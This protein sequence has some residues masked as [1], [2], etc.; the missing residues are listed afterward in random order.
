MSTATFEANPDSENEP[1]IERPAIEGSKFRIWH[2][3]FFSF[4]AFSFLVVVICCCVRIRIPRTK[5]EIEADYQRKKVANKFKKRLKHIN[6]Q[7]MES[8][9][10]KRALE[11]IIETDFQSDNCKREES[12][13][14]EVVNSESEKLVAPPEIGDRPKNFGKLVANVMKLGKFPPGSEVSNEEFCQRWD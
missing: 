5:Q 12:M 13:P 8:I 7:V 9:D 6:D 11:I 3:M 2:L 14:C 10:L 1:W 4:C